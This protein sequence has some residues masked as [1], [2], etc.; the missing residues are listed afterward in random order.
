MGKEN[1]TTTDGFLLL[2]L[3]SDS[4]SPEFL[5]SIILLTYVIAVAGNSILILLIWLDSHLHTPMYILL[6]QL[7]VMDLTLSSST[8]T[9]MATDFFS[10]KKNISRIGCGTQMFF[11]LTVGIAE[12]VFL[13]LM[14]YDRYV[15]ICNPLRYLVLMSPRVCLL[16]VMTAWVGSVLTSLSHTIYI[17]H[18]PTCG[19]REIHHFFCEVMAFLKLSCEDTSIYEKLVLITS[20]I[21]TIIPFGLILA[22]YALIFL[23]VLRMNSPNVRN[24]TL[25]TCTSHLSVVSLYF[26]PVMIIYMTPASSLP[27]ELDQHLFVFDTIITPLLN[28]LIYS[29]RNKEVIRALQ[30]VLGISLKSK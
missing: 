29:L 27:L 18:F 9:K 4:K 19:S 23:T 26:G 16:M 3:F 11:Y 30:M 6:S 12:C 13:T 8:V 15:A 7:S 14:A 17:M 28:P 21:L 25:V 22:S 1:E 5:I 10:G 24:K 20:S 2:G